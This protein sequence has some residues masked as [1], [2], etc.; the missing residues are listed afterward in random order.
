MG[1]LQVSIVFTLLELFMN[2][3]VINECPDDCVR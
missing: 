1:P 3:H 2:L